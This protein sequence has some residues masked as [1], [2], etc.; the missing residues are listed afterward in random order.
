MECIMR[1][2]PSHMVMPTVKSR[3]SLFSEN[4]LHELLD[5][6]WKFTRLSEAA[7]S[8]IGVRLLESPKPV[9]CQVR[10]IR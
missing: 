2:D 8:D 5:T 1:D 10:V 7:A 9:R 4:Y 6:L 3:F